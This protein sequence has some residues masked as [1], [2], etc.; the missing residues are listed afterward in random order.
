MSYPN[1]NEKTVSDVLISGGVQVNVDGKTDEG[2]IREASSEEVVPEGT[3]GWSVGATLNVDNG[4]GTSTAYVNT[5]DPTGCRFIRVGMQTTTQESFPFVH[6]PAILSEPERGRMATLFNMKLSRG[7]FGVAGLRDEAGA[8]A[9]GDDGGIFIFSAAAIA[10]DFVEVIHDATPPGV[11]LFVKVVGKYAQL[12]AD[13]SGAGMSYFNT[14]DNES[15]IVHDDPNADLG[16]ELGVIENNGSVVFKI[17]APNG[18][19]WLRG[20]NGKEFEIRAENSAAPQA[21]FDRT[22]VLETA[23]VFANLTTLGAANADVEIVYAGGQSNTS[24]GV[25]AITPYLIPD[26]DPGEEIRHNFPFVPINFAA[27]VFGANKMVEILYDP[28]AGSLGV[29][30]YYNNNT[31]QVEADLPDEVDAVFSTSGR[32]TP[33]QNVSI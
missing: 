14:D 7:T 24:E 4:D 12:C 30:F 5:G 18:K 32:Y 22:V 31:Q 3:K 10:Y 23:R 25:V 2:Y 27:D 21:Y 29:D 1:A 17:S 15:F 9:F 26:A 8:M 28:N 16:Y 11:P 20:A 13:M 6:N 19:F 33:F